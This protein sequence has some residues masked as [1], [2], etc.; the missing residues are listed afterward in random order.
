MLMRT[1]LLGSS[2]LFIAA[3]QAASGD[4]TA[5][6]ST[7]PAVTPAAVEIAASQP[8]D[9]KTPSP[10][11]TESTSASSEA[12]LN[13]PEMVKE[14]LAAP[15]VSQAAAARPAPVRPAAVQST[16]AAPVTVQQPVPVKVAAVQPAIVRAPDARQAA[17][18]P[19]AAPQPVLIAQASST[20]DTAPAAPGPNAAYNAFLSKYVVNR[21]GINLVRY[22]DVSPSDRAS[23]QGYIEGLSRSGPPSGSDD[24]IMAYWFN[25]YNAKTVELILE[26]YPLKSIRDISGPWKKKRLTVA[27][28]PMSLNDIEHKT[29]C[30]LC[31]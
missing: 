28:K 21:G 2:L 17:P 9:V 24:A 16:A 18:K 11:T 29:A 23:L 19:A 25:L 5:E 13:A 26:N 7:Q 22:G 3:C 14:A 30:A 4:L 8:T 20:P 31:V 10:E 1:L 15:I 6:A 12:E 27:G